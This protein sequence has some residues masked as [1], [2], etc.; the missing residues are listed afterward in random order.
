MFTKISI[1]VKN[2]FTESDTVNEN[3]EVFQMK[4]IIMGLGLLG[5]LVVSQN[6]ICEEIKCEK[7]LKKYKDDLGLLV[8]DKNFGTVYVSEDK[9]EFKF[10]SPEISVIYYNHKTVNFIKECVREVMNKTVVRQCDDVIKIS[11]AGLKRKEK[12]LDT[13]FYLKTNVECPTTFAK[14]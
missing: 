10:K 14:K 9:S 6:G 3:L 2:I 8:A 13:K 5:V 12:A 11:Q 1:N 4:K 7:T